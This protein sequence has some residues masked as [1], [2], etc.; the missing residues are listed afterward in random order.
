MKPDARSDRVLGEPFQDFATYLFTVIW[1]S[2]SMRS[3][4]W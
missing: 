3:G 1:R 4:A 2:I